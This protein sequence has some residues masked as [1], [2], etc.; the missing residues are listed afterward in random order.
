MDMCRFTG[1]GDIEYKKVAAALH[2]IS[3][4]VRPGHKEESV[5]L[6]DE[7][8]QNLL[9]S[10]RFDQID[11]RRMTI[12]RAHAKTCEWLLKTTEYS[13]WLDLTKLQEHFGFL[14][15]KGHPG[16]GKSTLMKFTLANS[17]RTIK[18]RTIISFF[19][20]ARGEVLEKT[21]T[22]MSTHQSG[23]VD[24]KQKT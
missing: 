23:G 6:D 17:Q 3:R 14:W 7:Q 1:P 18:N 2:R 9:D 24:V 15:I 8:R 10:L 11:A 21:T 13:N 12:Q 22:G 5:T 16:T 4:Q 20:N 19:F